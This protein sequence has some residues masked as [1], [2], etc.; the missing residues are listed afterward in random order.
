M[1]LYREYGLVVIDQT[2]GT[3]RERLKK[4]II[5]AFKDISFKITI[6]I[7]STSTDFLDVLLNLVTDY[8]QV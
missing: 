3:H 2:S 5:K 4:K 7:R 8:Y 6:E 1:G